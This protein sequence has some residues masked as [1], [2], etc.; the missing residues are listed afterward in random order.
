MGIDDG[1]AQGAESAGG[2]ETDELRATRDALDRERQRYQELFELAPD[3]YLLTDVHGLICEANRAA[4]TL[5]G[6]EHKYL[7]RK[8]LQVFVPEGDR[9]EF[10]RRVV[11]VTDRELP[12]EWRVRMVP[13]N[14]GPMVVAVVA[15]VVRERNGSFGGLR[16]SLRDITARFREEEQL[17]DMNA[18]LERRVAERTNALEAANALKDDLLER[19]RSARE[20]SDAANRAKDDFLATL[21]HELRTPLNVLLGL[22]FRLRT[23]TV[24][25]MQQP[26]TIET[27]ERNARELSRLVEDLLDTARIRSGHL[28]LNLC[29]LDLGGIVQSTI[30]TAEPT[31]EVRGITL[32]ADLQPNVL[33]LCDSERLRQ[34]VWNLLSNA[35]KFTPEGGVISVR[36]GSESGSAT[37]AITDTGIGIDPQ[38]IPRV[39]ERFWQGDQSPGRSPAGLGLGLAIVKDLVEMHGGR[40]TAFSD[41]SGHGSTFTVVLPAVDRAESDPLVEPEER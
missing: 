21:S 34:I 23:G 17:K 29:R 26:R 4:S 16:W 30:E 37:I 24:P 18:E 28:R 35:L 27:L 40:I 10:R 22:L 38:V 5:L 36:V 20:A 41:G 31:A 12:T 3:S 1:P 2:G 32:E 15:R 9:R 6:V 33:A 8:P 7:L 39:F 14:G 11:Q 13:R 25:P 19:E